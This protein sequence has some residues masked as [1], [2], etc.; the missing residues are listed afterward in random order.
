MRYPV[1]RMQNADPAS[2]STARIFTEI[3]VNDEQ[4]LSLDPITSSRPSDCSDED[5]RALALDNRLL[6]H[7]IMSMRDVTA[8]DDSA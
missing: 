7:L 5:E 8:A 2:I 1:S 4:R 6:A 3:A